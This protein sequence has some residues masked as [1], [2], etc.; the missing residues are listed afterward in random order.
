[1]SSFI[2]NLKELSDIVK[3]HAGSDLTEKS[4]PILSAVLG[5]FD[6][7]L[8]SLGA[9]KGVDNT[10]EAA[11]REKSTDWG[12][13]LKDTAD[14]LQTH[15]NLVQDG[16]SQALRIDEDIRVLIDVVHTKVAKGGID[17]KGYLMERVIQ[18]A[19]SLPDGS[20]TQTS[21]TGT[22]I[23]GLWDSLQHPPLSYLGDENEYRTAD[24]SNNSFLYPKLGMAGTP[25]ARSVTPLTSG[26]LYPD[27]GEVFDK[28]LARQ[29]P[30]KEHPNKVSSMLFYLATLIIHDLF[31]TGD[32]TK[33]DPN[34]NFNISS[35]SSYLDLSPLY[36]NN[37]KEQEAVRTMKDGM[38]KP[39]TFSEHRL[40]GFPPGVCALL[41]TF[42]R[43]HNYVSGELKR[44]NEDGRFNPNPRLSNKDA[45]KEIDNALHQRTGSCSHHERRHAQA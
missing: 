10:I 1:M 21:L 11:V 40:L 27:P 14:F 45:E 6:S 9:G 5:R 44:I 15:K 39:D 17:D 38:L 30:P 4:E 3:S 12:L 19:T 7:I 36:G 41:I 16:Q 8:G 37:I 22:L 29:G 26:R 35:T 18:L 31:R 33:N 43:F 20:T 24:G 2:P 34:P 28:L 32:D 23:K 25:Y 42:N 13:L